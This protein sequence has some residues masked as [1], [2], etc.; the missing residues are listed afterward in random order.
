MGSSPR[1]ERRPIGFSAECLT[2][3]QAFVTATWLAT[4]T[5]EGTPITKFQQSNAREMEIDKRPAR[6]RNPCVIDGSVISL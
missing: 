1:G 2:F 6:F 4:A 3:G 5:P